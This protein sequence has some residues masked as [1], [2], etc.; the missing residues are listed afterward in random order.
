MRALR[1]LTALAVAATAAFAATPALAADPAS[2]TPASTTTVASQD[3][4]PPPESQDAP[5]AASRAAVGETTTWGDSLGRLYHRVDDGFDLDQ[6]LGRGLLTFSFNIDKTNY[7]PVDDLGHPTHGNK[8][9]GKTMLLTLRAWDVDESQGEVDLVRFNDTE[10]APR[11]LSGA[12]SQWATDTFEI[13]TSVLRLPTPSNP[14]GTNVVDVHVDMNN[15]GWAVEIDWAELRVDVATDAI[16]PVILPHGIT[17]IGD[18]TAEDKRSGMRVMDDYLGDEIPALRGRTSALT[19]S[20]N[21]SISKNAGIIAGQINTL[22]ELEPSR[23]VDVVAHSKGGLDARL[24]A[25]FN[26][27]RVRNL[28]MIA[29]PNHGSEVAEVLCMARMLRVDSLEPAMGRC[30]GPENGLYQLN[31]KYVGY[32]NEVITDLPSVNYTTIAGGVGGSQQGLPGLGSPILGGF[33]PGQLGADD[34]AVSVESVRWLSKY[35]P[36]HPGLHVSQRPT[37]MATHMGLIR[38]IPV[39][40]GEPDLGAKPLSFP[41]AACAIA[42]D[43]FDDCPPPSG[44]WDEEPSANSQR[45]SAAA[46]GPD[47]RPQQGIGPDGTVA[48]GA[49]VDYEVDVLPDDQA[50]LT[51]LAA[52]GLNVTI[53]G[54]VF[55]DTDIFGTPSH[56]ADL[57]GPTTLTVHNPTDGPLS[58]ETILVVNSTRTLTLASPDYVAAGAPLVVEATMEGATAD[59]VLTYT[60]RGPT[61]AVVAQGNLPA[62][63]PGVWQASIPSPGPGIY[64]TVVTA[65]GPG[66]R[67]AMDIVAVLGGGKFTGDYTQGIADNDFDGLID[68]LSLDIPVEVDH[69]GTHSVSVRVLDAA[70]HLVTTGGTRQHV[71]GSGTFSLEFDGRKIHDAASAGPWTVE[72]VL[73]DDALNIRDRVTLG[74]ITQDDPQNYEHDTLTVTEFTDEGIDP[75][76]N[77]LIDTLRISAVAR[78]DNAG[79]YAINGKLVATDGTVVGRASTTAQV[80]AGATTIKLDFNGNDIGASGHDGPYIL[81]DLAVY[82]KDSPDEGLTLVDA[83]RTAAYRSAQFPGGHASDTPPTASFRVTTLDA[84]DATLDASTSTDDQGIA[85]YT[86]DLGDGTTATGAVVH[87]HYAAP[88]IYTATLTVTDSSGQ[89]ATTSLPVT[90]TPPLCQ[91][92]PATI[93]GTGGNIDGTHGDDVIVGTSASERID[94][95]NGNDIICGGGGDDT[96]IGSHGNDTLTG[97]AGNDVID[98]G[99]GNDTIYGGGGNDTLTGSHDDDF[100]DGGDGDDVIDGGDGH[101]ALQGGAGND[102]IVAGHGDDII[103]GGPGDDTIDG[104]S[105]N[106]TIQDAP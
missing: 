9:Y 8:L 57:A 105:G 103:D 94:G 64:S 2:P 80:A 86:W 39:P 54:A 22:V 26:P 3:E 61:G 83:H 91:G 42:P 43:E 12:N 13:P 82:P 87:H 89:S 6:Y 19:T 50:A 104:G 101:D 70:G 90:A 66:A 53:A 67:A 32:F 31:R 76:S 36:D 58:F 102:T 98:G 72:A 55:Q 79:T 81:R 85:T 4:A 96:L 56:T 47:V 40:E 68:T 23:T 62:G 10:A 46:P 44:P 24:Y 52:A 78:T 93:I 65:T 49:T 71:D 73:A 38:S 106:N 63:A 17:D 75:D 41:M 25:F 18:E 16:L 29:T 28:V 84:L 37:V 14:T 5:A 59:E 20:E 92:L 69:A 74:T 88:G 34:M 48:A 27:G 60:V 7:G 11:T 15:D 45:S 77:G 95:G 100:I 51:V 21:G 97:G 1:T 99:T 30:D 33:G 35:D